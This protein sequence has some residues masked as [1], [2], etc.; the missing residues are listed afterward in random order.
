M[1]D[2]R[3]GKDDSDDTADS[4]PLFRM[5][6]VTFERLLNSVSERGLSKTRPPT[7][8]CLK[9]PRLPVDRMA[10]PEQF[11]YSDTLEGVAE[12]GRFLSNQCIDNTNTI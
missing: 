7:V 5:R 9:C 4:K 8:T 11:D 1:S 12:S 10:N 3:D 6:G 2:E